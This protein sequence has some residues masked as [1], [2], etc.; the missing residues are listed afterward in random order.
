M[1]G[2]AHRKPVCL[3]N[4]EAGQRCTPKTKDMHSLSNGECGTSDTRQRHTQRGVQYIRYQAETHLERN[5][6]VLSEEE[7]HSTE[8]MSFTYQ[9][10]PSGSLFTLGQLFLS[11]HLSGP[12]FRP[13]MYVQLFAKMD[14]TVEAYGCISTLIMKWGPLIFLLPRRLPAHVETG[15]LP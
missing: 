12:Q 2:R 15:S 5:A 9:D 13:K 14:P 7:Q 3:S 1:Y 8:V 6:G 4:S 10:S 11:S